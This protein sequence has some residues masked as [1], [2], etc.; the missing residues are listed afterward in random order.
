MVMG[1]LPDA[2][3]TRCK[4]SVARHVG[5]LSAGGAA[6]RHP[7]LFRNWAWNAISVALV[8]LIGLIA[9]RVLHDRLGP[10][11]YGLYLLLTALGGMTAFVDLGV[12]QS[13]LR[14]GAYYDQLG[15]GVAIDRLVGWSLG[16]HLALG[17]VFVGLLA[18]GGQGLVRLLDLQPGAVAQVA[19]L[20]PWLGVTLTAGTL[21]A[22]LRAVPQ[23]L[24]RYDIVGAAEVALTTVRQAGMIAV[25]GV[26]G[27]LTG[28][29]YWGVVAA[30][31]AVVVYACL[32]RRLVPAVRLRPRW[33]WHYAGEVVR[34]GLWTYATHAVVQLS[35]E[36]DQ[37]V[38]GATGAIAD[39]SFLNVPRSLLNRLWEMQA[40]VTRV[41]FARFSRLES[42]HDQAKLL[43][44]SVWAASCLAIMLFV[45]T[46]VLFRGILEVWMGPAFAAQSANV[47]MLIA[48]SMA[49]KGAF[50][51]NVAFLQG[52]GRV[53]WLA[54]MALA[55]AVLS[56]VATAVLVPRFGLMGAGWRYWSGVVASGVSYLYVMRAVFPRL[57]W[58]RWLWRPLL[59]PW[60]T[61][62]LVTIAAALWVASWPSLGLMGVML[63]WL[64][65][66][67]VLGALLLG[68]DLALSREE[69]PAWML[70]QR[71]LHLCVRIRR[72]GSHRRR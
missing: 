39:V 64:A 55:G 29:V 20:L 37:F 65:L 66:V 24:Q 61:G 44:S 43:R 50:V 68:V 11:G 2:S 17:G 21:S 49:L 26:G 62:A 38:L 53:S 48:G 13:V 47:A 23:A 40:S 31:L 60:V 9:V 46:L 33:P 22:S 71:G 5:D 15:D 34:Y 52:S 12:P 7:G 42:A 27:G 56:I 72:R 25:V 19:R 63:A 58:C 3:W 4:H 51:P 32:A 28:L 35:G 6:R 36:L 18:V 41:L 16:V 54:V 8:S 30:V 45:P 10:T 1:S 14:Y 69:G 67:V 57:A 70:V 59:V